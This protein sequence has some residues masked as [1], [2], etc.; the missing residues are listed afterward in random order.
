MS[1]EAGFARLHPMCIQAR[2][3]VQHRSS[4]A[5]SFHWLFSHPFVITHQRHD[6]FGAVEQVESETPNAADTASSSSSRL[7][8]VLAA[9][10]CCSTERA[11]EAKDCNKCINMKSRR[12]KSSSV[13]CLWVQWTDLI[14]REKIIQINW[15]YRLLPKYFYHGERQRTANQKL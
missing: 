5:V 8:F 1:E 9:P 13:T 3:L 7:L 4:R 15:S 14:T 12:G 10:L 11:R 2:S 6:A